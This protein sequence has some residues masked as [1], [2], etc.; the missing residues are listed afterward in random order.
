M[1]VLFASM[2]CSVEEIKRNNARR[3]AT[4]IPT[5]NHPAH[6]DTRRQLGEK[7]H[8]AVRGRLADPPVAAGPQFSARFYYTNTRARTHTHGY[9]KSFVLDTKGLRL[10]VYVCWCGI[11]KEHNEA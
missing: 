8:P 3:H 10:R 1:H 11:V 5:P 7:G 9:D 2:V 6:R 4:E